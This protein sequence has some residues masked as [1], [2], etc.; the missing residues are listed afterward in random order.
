MPV[1]DRHRYSDIQLKNDRLSTPNGDG[2]IVDAAVLSGGFSSAHLAELAE[3]TIPPHQDARAA[4][5]A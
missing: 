5:Q 1:I 3:N 4:L 2:V